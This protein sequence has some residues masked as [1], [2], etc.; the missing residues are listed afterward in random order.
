MYNQI[1]KNIDI[2]FQNFE[3]D[4]LDGQFQT[5]LCVTRKT[6]QII[7]T[8]L[9]VPELDVKI[10][11]F[12]LLFS[13]KIK[14]DQINIDSLKLYFSQKDNYKPINFH[15]I[16]PVLSSLTN[17]FKISNITF[18]DIHVVYNQFHIDSIDI[19][20][21]GFELGKNLL[22][23]KEF[24]VNKDDSYIQAN[25]ALNKQEIALNVSDF[26]VTNDNS[27]NI[28]FNEPYCRLLNGK[29][30]NLE[31]Y[32][33]ISKDSLS[34]STKLMLENS[35]LTM[36]LL[37]TKDTCFVMVD[38]LGLNMLDFNIIPHPDNNINN[39]YLSGDIT[40]LKDPLYCNAIFDSEYGGISIQFSPLLN[41]D[42]L[43]VDFIDFDLGYMLQKNVL[44]Q[45][46]SNI[47]IDFD[48]NLEQLNIKTSI[49]DLV[50]KN[51][52]YKNCFIQATFDST[53]NS[54]W[55]IIV[56]DYN[57]AINTSLSID[58]YYNSKDQ[59]FYETSFS[60]IIDKI[61]LKNLNLSNSNSL[62]FISTKFFV[63]KF[64]F[65]PFN[66]PSKF[67]DW[68]SFQKNHPLIIG[69]KDIEYTKNNQKEVVDYIDVILQKNSFS[70]ESSIGVI[71]ANT[72]NNKNSMFFYLDN[73]DLLLS[74][75]TP[76][77]IYLNLNKAS[78]F[79][80]LFFNNLSFPND[81]FFQINN[82][83]DSLYFSSSAIDIASLSMKEVK[84][85]QDKLDQKKYSLLID[86]VFFSDKYE[87][88]SVE[89]TA[90]FLDNLKGDYKLTY[91]SIDRNVKQAEVTGDFNLKDKGLIFDFDQKSF[92]TLSDE[93]WELQPSSRLLL[94]PHSINFDNFAITLDD[95][96]LLLDGQIGKN[97]NI[98]FSFKNFSMQHAVPFL[99][100]SNINFDGILNGDASYNSRAF[101]I[102]SGNF[103]V[104]QFVFNNTLLGSLDLT[105]YTNYTNDSL[106]TKG[107]IKDKFE[108]MIFTAKYP[109]D[110]TKSI[111]ADFD[112]NQFPADV[113]DVF[114]KP[115]SNLNGLSEG[116]ITLNGMINQ[117]D[118][119]GFVSIDDLS[120]RIPYLQIDYENKD[121]PLLLDFNQNVIK[122]N[123][124]NLYDKKHNTHALFNGK[125][126]H[127][128]LK[129]ISYDLSVKTDSLFTLNTTKYDNSTYYGNVFLSADMSIQGSAGKNSIEINGV[130][131]DGS[132]LMIPLSNSKEIKANEFVEFSSQNNSKVQDLVLF[133]TNK[134]SL[135]MDFNLILDNQSEIQ[136]IFDEE[137]GDVIK[138]YGQGDLYLKL[139]DEED[140]EIFGDFEIEQG[141]YLFTLQDVI[142]KSFIIDRGGVISFNGSIDNAILNL[143]LLYNIQASLYMLNPDYDRDKK[144]NVIC[145]MAMTGPL[146]NPEINFFIEIPNADQII[147]TSLESLTNTDQKLLE[148]FLYLLITNSFL[149]ENDS[150]ID[151]LENTLAITGTELLSNQL[152]NWLSQTTDAV[153]LGF[154]W[155][156]GTGDSLS[157]QQVELAVSKKFLNDRV[158]IN[159]NV[160]TPPEQSEA[161]IIGDVDIEYD[162]FKDGRLKLRV[163]NRSQDYDPLSESSGY[164]QGFGLFFKKQFNS[165]KELFVNKKEKQ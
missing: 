71:K 30:F 39:L 147:E 69:L 10:S 148:Q 50:F 139:S 112:F 129:N 157:Y 104:N 89:L 92:I 160:S 74:R 38:T 35:F 156:P 75:K 34:I 9:F 130:S 146:L 27:L 86:R 76:F 162:F 29:N 95:Q 101:P 8:V 102:F 111:Q 12:D 110:G 13:D 98:L 127:S 133:N 143:N 80:D 52:K 132:K 138:G 141:N 103:Q 77:D 114:I 117:Y 32:F 20:I 40:V 83:K 1:S 21:Q 44:G 64:H 81:L 113:L 22:S 128:S 31:S 153:D 152:S 66:N 72:L 37:D 158:I 134:S 82:K 57:L 99:K 78:F 136:L 149:I 73:I 88:N 151:Y 118:V 17:T 124:I 125:L 91:S 97:A 116:S 163:F 19:M 140:F 105:N 123:N 46:N 106:Y 23:I 122:I 59:I 164:E 41:M 18:K 51:Y 49:E 67:I 28:L 55:D 56:D 53:Y 70:L 94:N 144:S 145:R 26:Y 61:N 36:N 54:T 108:T 109:L 14:L 137:V 6:D 135:N 47:K 79:S 165:L 25:F 96:M 131:Q 43:I 161:N 68:S 15:T 84:F 85:H 142:T 45:I 60:G 121:D 119:N 120:F 16:T 87:F 90:N 5:D 100:E 126:H 115:I 150:T 2:L 24:R 4:V 159:G 62:N 42:K 154:K 3:Y 107:I 63:N 155:I 33:I 65:K 48:R 11:L 58:T 93:T 7:D